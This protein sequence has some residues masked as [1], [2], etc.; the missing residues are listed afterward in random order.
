MNWIALLAVI[1]SVPLLYLTGH[2]LCS[3]LKIIGANRITQRTRK[4]IHVG[5]VMGK[6]VVITSKVKNFYK[7]TLFV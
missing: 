4:N 1:V 2:Y 7:D 6:Y 3:L 5:L